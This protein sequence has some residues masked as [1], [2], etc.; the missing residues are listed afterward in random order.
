M[1]ASSFVLAGSGFDGSNESAAHGAG[2]ALSRGS[3]MKGFDKE[4]EDFLQRFRVV[5]PVDLRLR[6]GSTRCGTGTNHDG[7]RLSK[8]PGFLADDKLGCVCYSKTRKNGFSFISF[9]GFAS[10]G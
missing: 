8:G 9:A 5:T 10:N 2:R 1:G 7:Q 3:S 4:F 6:N